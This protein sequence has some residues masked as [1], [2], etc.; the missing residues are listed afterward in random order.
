M[1]IGLQTRA[2]KDR[3][4]QYVCMYVLCPKLTETRDL[5]TEILQHVVQIIHIPVAPK[6]GYMRSMIEHATSGHLRRVFNAH[7]ALPFI[8]PFL[9]S[10]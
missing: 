2:F 1:P 7:V 5:R 6:A 3:I 8:F 9:F 4:N 10:V